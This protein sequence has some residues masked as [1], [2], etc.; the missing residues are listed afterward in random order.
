MSL[1]TLKNHDIHLNMFIRRTKI[2]T[3]VSGGAYYT[4]RLVASKRIG[5]KVRQQTLL[6]LGHNFSLPKEQWPQLCARIDDILTGQ[7][8]LENQ[9]VEIEKI[10]QHYAA[11]L[12]A[13]RAESQDILQKKITDYQEVDVVSLELLRP[14]SIGVE[15]VGLETIKLL[16]LPKILEE[17]GLNKVQRDVAVG[18][19]IGRMAEPGSERATWQWLTEQ[20]GI[21]ELLDVDFEAMSAMRLYRVSDLL[22]QHRQQIEEALFANISDLFSLTTTVTL[23]DL[24][25]TF[26]EGVMADNDKALRGHSKEKRTD[27][28]LV[29]L[30]LVLDGSGFVRGSQMF[31]GNIAESQ[32]LETM[33]EKLKA[34]K[35]S[36]V[37]MDRGIATQANIDWLIEHHYR[38]LVVSRERA[39]SF[40][41][42]QA[43]NISTISD[44]PIKIQ[45]VISED[46]DE[47]RLYCYSD[48]RQEKERAITERFVKRFEAGLQ[49]IADSLAKPHGTKKQDKVL[50]RIGRL[51]EKNNGIGQHYQ[52]S[53]KLDETGTT[54]TS[55]TWDQKSVDGTKLTHPGIYCLRTNE[56]R[57]DEATLWKT[58]TMLTDLEAVFRSLKSE[59]GLR[60][61]YH[62][63]E[64]RADGHLFITVL[65]YQAV[66]VMR[67]R[68]KSNGI[69][70]SW[71]SLR[72]I[73]SGQQRVTATFK[74]KDDHIL[75]I[76][77]T[78]IAEPKLKKLYD[79][80]GISASPA[81]VQKTI[82]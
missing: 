17:A 57:W 59:L 81:G 18:S 43:V 82:N 2:G 41:A 45:R 35:K 11:R 12:I 34:P 32:T 42:D 64:E 48:Q 28:P 75:H 53:L 22:V 40:D 1:I 60:P 38:Y 69:N 4:F 61:V 58:Y 62:H 72:K 76:R 63:K 36:L 79:A 74:Q 68:L 25:N 19:I 66:Q 15:H 78:T 47:V 14:R 80:L 27:C 44:H 77:K 37:I 56:L 54:V 21:G 67:R 30:G 49:K 52:I 71:T 6:N 20:S 10:A 5:D 31:A 55:I 39:R 23:Y 13:N 51:K 16:D 26:F 70:D 46:G 50:E 65:A 9:S 8:T 7:L 29:T 73:F 33:L 3:A 24:T